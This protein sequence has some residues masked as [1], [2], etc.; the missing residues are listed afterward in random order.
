MAIQIP[1]VR[2]L[3]S[4]L[5]V[6]QNCIA[7]NMVPTTFC[8]SSTTI[9]R[10]L[11]DTC[12]GPSS[13]TAVHVSGSPIDEGPR[14]ACQRGQI[15]TSPQAELQVHR[16]GFQSADRLDV[17]PR[18]QVSEGTTA[19]TPCVGQPVIIPQDMAITIST[20]A[21]DGGSGTAGSPAHTSVTY[22]S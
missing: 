14:L 3:N 5:C 12:T 21:V 13:D 2:D 16:G 7:V 6:H 10:R 18:G 17:P 20:A 8:N 1:P 19:I 15:G 4:P 11:D 9:H 22:L